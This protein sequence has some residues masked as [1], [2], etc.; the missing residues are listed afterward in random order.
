MWKGGSFAGVSLRLNQTH[1][2]STLAY[3]EMQTTTMCLKLNF[4]ENSPFDTTLVDEATGNMLYKIETERDPF[5]GKTTVIRR[6]HSAGAF[7]LYID[8]YHFL[9]SPAQIDR[10]NPCLTPT[11][12]KLGRSSGSRGRLT[13]SC[14]ADAR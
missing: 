12:T 14:M 10:E 2:P 11:I 6:L 4:T 13:W 9:N 5:S 1:S 8:V 3:F 7:F